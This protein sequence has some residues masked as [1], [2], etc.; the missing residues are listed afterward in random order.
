[1]FIVHITGN[2]PSKRDDWSRVY[3]DLAQAKATAT[4]QTTWTDY[5]SEGGAR[6][7]RK[8]DWVATVYEIRPNWDE[9]D[10]TYYGDFHL[11]EVDV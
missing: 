9:L 6:R 11:M 10:P 1:M 3:T 7:R 8:G 2:S 5:F 4:R